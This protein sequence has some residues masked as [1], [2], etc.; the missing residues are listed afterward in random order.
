MDDLVRRDRA[1]GGDILNETRYVLMDYFSPASITDETGNVTERYQFSAFGL[2][3]ILSPAYT[4]RNSSE[5]EM[6]FGFQGQ[7]E[8]ADTGWLNYGYRYYLPELGRWTCKD[9]VGEVGGTNLYAMVANNPVGVVDR[10]GLSIAGM[11]AAGF[12]PT[13]A[14][15]AS[16]AA[17]SMAPGVGMAAMM[18]QIAQS[19]TQCTM[20]EF[21]GAI[22]CDS[23]TGQSY[24]TTTYQGDQGTCPVGMATR[25]C[26]D[27]GDKVLSTWHT[28]P[29]KDR[30][31][32]PGKFSVDKYYSDQ[33]GYPSVMT[34]SDNQTTVYDPKTGQ[35]TDYVCPSK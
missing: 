12:P 3:T 27:K 22:C 16:G 9:P 34:N 7:F 15:G 35:E 13:A 21:C 32:E 20:V 18:S 26:E 24:A 5:C 29:N 14:M 30:Q 17:S 31:T 4:V 1:V 19:Q 6:E 2:R 28:H 33:T 25:E 23:K 11:M 10:F 8:D